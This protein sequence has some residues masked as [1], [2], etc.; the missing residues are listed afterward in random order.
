[1]AERPIFIP[2][3]NSGHL[4]EEVFLPIQWHSGFAPIQKERNILEL[5]T[6]ARAAGFS[7]LLEVSTKSE[8]TAGR[9]LSAFHLKVKTKGH[10]CVPLECVFQGSKVFEQG[11]PYTDL[12]SKDVREAKKDNRLRESGRIIGFELD[13]RSF[14]LEPKTF[15]Y[16]WLYIGAIF[17]HREWLSRLEGYAGFTDIEFNPQKSINCQAR[18]MALFIVL[19]RRNLLEEAVGSPENFR[20]ILLRYRY[21]PDLKSDCNAQRTLFARGTISGSD[22]PIIQS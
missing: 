4:V 8:R 18:S 1:M 3:A 17:E 9:H 11:G 16:D 19:K 14:S 21:C 13:G 7:P 5:H 10:G 6:A 12:Y 15:F 20:R 2:A 22:T